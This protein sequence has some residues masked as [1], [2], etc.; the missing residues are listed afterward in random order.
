MAVIQIL[1][2]FVLLFVGGE[3]VVRGAVALANRFG[4]SPLVIGL[5]IVGFGTS[6]PELWVSLNAALGGSPGIAVGNVV[7]SNMANMMLVMGCAALICPIMVNPAAVRRDAS[8]MLAVTVI[9]IA[10]GMAGTVSA[11][12]GLAMV[13]M[14][15]GYLGY[16]LWRDTK[17][18]DA[19]AALHRE[20]AEELAG[21]PRALWISLI[22]LLAGFAAVGY[23]ADLLVDGATTLARAAGVA[24]A[25]IGLTVVAVGTSLPELAT[26]IVAAYRGHSDVCL[27]NVLGSNIFNLFGIMG[28]TALAVPVP[29]PEQILQFD[30]WALLFVSLLLIPFMLFGRRICRVEGGVFLALYAGY[31]TAQFLGVGGVV[32]AVTG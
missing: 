7:G 9:F 22:E 4:V 1:G 25:V 17:D 14:L 26:S 11:L 10:I 31:V 24:D 12:E 28:V 5:T 20:E 16:S 19:A 8:F 23:G 2:G 27:G 21:R 29:F 3:F 32:A 18:N 13:V 30:L 15:L 6:L